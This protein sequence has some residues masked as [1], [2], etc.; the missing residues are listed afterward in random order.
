MPK[1]V[2][3]AARAPDYAPWREPVP[4]A[5]AGHRKAHVDSD[6]P[7]RP[8]LHRPATPVHVGGAWKTDH[9]VK[10]PR[11]ARRGGGGTAPAPVADSQPVGAG[12]RILTRG[13]FGPAK[14]RRL[15]EAG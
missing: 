4:R 10:R 12:A 3:P 11:S 7:M 15:P 9:A 6:R 8:G 14:V 2:H 1:K 5:V 13:K